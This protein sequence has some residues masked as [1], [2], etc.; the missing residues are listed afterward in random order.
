MDGT[1]L[2]SSDDPTTWPDEV[3]NAVDEI[4]SSNPGFSKAKNVSDLRLEDG[5]R[6]RIIKAVEPIPLIAFH[7]S[8]LLPHEI[9]SVIQNGLLP[10]SE[11]FVRL[12][13]EQAISFGYLDPVSAA[14]FQNSSLGYL[15]R[16]TRA[17]LIFLTISRNALRKRWDSGPLVSNWGGEAMYGDLTK[18]PEMRTHLSMG[19]PVIVKTLF[20][21]GFSTIRL[22]HWEPASYLVAVRL[23]KETLGGNLLMDAVSP[24]QILKVVTSDDPEWLEIFLSPFP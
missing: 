23:K 6:D 12:R 2:L 20:R 9:D 4:I 17:P 5:E 14:R 24:Q 18:S 1:D 19:R 21:L 15:R 22:T 10:P 8:R 3:I 16:R 13:I 7:A 11:E